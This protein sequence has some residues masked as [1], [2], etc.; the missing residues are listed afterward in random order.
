[1]LDHEERIEKLEERVDLSAERSDEVEKR[2]QVMAGETMA[3]RLI[4]K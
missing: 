1:L 2:L 3:G 4:R